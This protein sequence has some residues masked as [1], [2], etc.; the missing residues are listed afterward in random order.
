MIFIDIIITPYVFFDRGV[1][2][3]FNAYLR[4]MNQSIQHAGWPLMDCAT[5]ADTFHPLLRGLAVLEP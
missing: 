5:Q 1:R 2:L 4:V 3:A